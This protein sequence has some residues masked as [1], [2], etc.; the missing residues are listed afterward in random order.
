MLELKLPNIAVLNDVHLKVPLRIFTQDGKL[1]T[2]FGEMHRI[3][4][5]LD[6]IPKQII[7][8]TLAT[9]DQRFY[10]HPGVDIIGLTRATIVLALTGKKLQG[11]STITMQVARNF[12][13]SRQKTY[14]RKIKEILLALE[15]DRELSKDK[16]LELYF[17][18]I[19]YGYRAYGIAAAAEVYYGKQ[20]DQLNLP[21]IAMLV[22][23]PKA[24]S[25][26]NPIDHPKAAIIRRNHVLERLRDVGYIDQATYNLS[27]E[28]PL[29]AK[30]HELTP[31]VKA[32][33]AAEMARQA[34]VAQL[35]ES[36]YDQGL[37]VYTTIQ[38]KNQ[39]IAN[40]SLE[41][42]LLAYD[43]RHG[44]R[45]PVG[46]LGQIDLNDLKTYVTQLNQFPTINDLNPALIINIDDATASA[47]L[48]SGTIISIPWENMRWAR[49][50]IMHN[51]QEYLGAKPS[52]P[53]D[54][55]K[56]GDVVYVQQKL[57]QTWALS[58]IPQA[59]SA[60][61]ALNPN[62][63][64]ILALCGGFNFYHSNFNRAIQALRQPG[65]AFK[66]FI[67]SAA[68]EKGFTLATVI[69]DAPVVMS[70]T[71]ANMLWRPENDTQKFYGPTRLR[72][73]LRKSR[74]LV[75]IRLLQLIGIPYA[76]DYV[77]RFG[78][79]LEQM[80]TT[81]SLALGTATLTPLQ[82]ATAYAVFANGGYKINPYLIDHI[83]NNQGQV[84]YQANPAIVPKDIIN[85]NGDYFELK[86]NQAPMMMPAQNDTARI[87]T[88][89]QRVITPQNA[90]LMT[91]A[92]KDVIARGTARASLI[93]HR[94]DLAGKTGTTNQ[95]M[96]GW[97][98]GFNS[99]LV[100]VTWIGFDQPRSLYEY[101]A[102]SVLPTWIDFMKYALK[103]SSLASMPEPDGIVS[104]RINKKTG[105]LT[106]ATDSDAIFELFRK[107]H[108]PKQSNHTP[109]LEEN[110]EEMGNNGLY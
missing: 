92:M 38:S 37:D 79:P 35:G 62:N 5:T 65:S 93:L 68:L 51:D 101:A 52:K 14:Y 30:Y 19:F 21:E 6:Q 96:D 11:G 40:F 9:E 89:A 100:A 47:L 17:N 69:N 3:P 75:S 72:V 56:S 57:G 97:F 18:K 34:V 24:P 55:L 80:P 103:G 70:D 108:V 73:A 20:L 84:I 48:K 107:Q 44:Y 67:Y 94:S 109:T 33:Y 43:Q 104:A 71:G 60:L 45:G 61:I 91:S 58:Q 1:I 23:L 64:A 31:S 15:I 28:A 74:N 50:Q 13:L 22:G 98:C 86:H 83:T 12:F 10:S 63:G 90:Y 53:A 46:N 41:K 36:V 85:N 16:I 39:T 8:A 54:V 105:L 27:I 7:D 42:N 110:S 106:N 2:E 77:T 49:Q 102:K 29:T 99:N 4:V 32:P 95:K 87:Q 25:V 81:L 78:F 76:I 88:Y 26:L 59:E 82:M 66:P